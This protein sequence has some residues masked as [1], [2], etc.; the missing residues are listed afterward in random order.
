MC[1]SGRICNLL[2]SLMCQLA[3]FCQGATIYQYVI[4]KAHTIFISVTVLLA[5]LSVAQ[6]KQITVNFID[7]MLLQKCN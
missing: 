5:C 3:V 2:L 1:V 4:L 7:V 6:A